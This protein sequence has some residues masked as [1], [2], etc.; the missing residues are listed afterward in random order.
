MTYLR[1]LLN[2]PA[3]LFNPSLLA[4]IHDAQQIPQTSLSLP[5]LIQPHFDAATASIATG[6][7]AY[8]VSLKVARRVRKEVV[9]EGLYSDS[10]M[11]VGEEVDPDGAEEMEGGAAIGW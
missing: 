7:L 9:D 10:E 3:S 11:V 6:L 1:A 5:S 4:T 8:V 2:I